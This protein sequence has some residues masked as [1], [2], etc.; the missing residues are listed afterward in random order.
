MTVCKD[1]IYPYSICELL[2]ALSFP[3]KEP[4]SINSMGVWVVHYTDICTSYMTG[5][6]GC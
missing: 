5:F 4:M 6:R 3:T 1:F 2:S